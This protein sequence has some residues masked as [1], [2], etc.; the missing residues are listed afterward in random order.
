MNMK[1][2]ILLLAFLSLPI[3]HAAAQTPPAAEP[4]A[5]PQSE[6]EKAEARA[7]LEKKALV[8]LEQTIGDAMSLRVPENR[9]RVLAGAAD[10]LWPR[11][12]KRARS[13]FRD[14]LLS[15]ERGGGEAA[16][17]ARAAAP[18][19]LD[20]ARRQAGGFAPGRAPRPAA[21]AR[22]LTGDAAGSAAARPE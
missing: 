7:E 2:L 10:L 19:L 5:S 6:K 8:M 18:R 12:E 17:R 22:T 1:R 16:A 15:L 3:G 9:V 4:Q 21:R 13:L 14:A 20:F 11:D